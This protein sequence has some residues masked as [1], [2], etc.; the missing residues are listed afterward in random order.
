MSPLVLRGRLVHV[1]LSVSLLFSASVYYIETYFIP[2]TRSWGLIYKYYL[3]IYLSTVAMICLQPLFLR[4][5]ISIGLF[6]VLHL[7]RTCN[8]HKARIVRSFCQMLLVLYLSSMRGPSGW[9]EF[10]TLYLFFPSP[11]VVINLAPLLA[12]YFLSTAN[13]NL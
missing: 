6:T 3:S 13:S 4:L 10:E 8:F 7:F 2:R 9:M 5:A 11:V 12:L 1:C